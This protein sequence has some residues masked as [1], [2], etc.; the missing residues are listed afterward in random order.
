M[1]VK[2]SYITVVDESNVLELSANDVAIY[3]NPASSVMNVRAE[4]MQ[5]I[6]IFDI[7]GRAVLEKEVNSDC[8]IVD[9]SM[10]NASAYAVRITTGYGT[11]VKNIVIE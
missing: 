2:E 5:H 1:E 3:P 10:L 9:V 7:T 8:E 11:I 6:C 4:G